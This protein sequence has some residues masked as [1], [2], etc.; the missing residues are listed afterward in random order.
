VEGIV[1][2]LE[3]AKSSDLNAYAQ[4]LFHRLFYSEIA[5]L[6]DHNTSRMTSEI[7]EEEK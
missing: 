5:H 7:P 4:I 6:I 3:A 1:E 2:E